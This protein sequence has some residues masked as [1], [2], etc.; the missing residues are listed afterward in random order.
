MSGELN[1]PYSRSM[2]PQI[3]TPIYGK[4]A[5]YLRR[6]FYEDQVELQGAPLRSRSSSKVAGPD[7]DTDT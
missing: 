1:V 5:K 2:K 7:L 4:Q 6:N 3:K